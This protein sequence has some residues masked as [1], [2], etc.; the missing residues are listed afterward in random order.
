MN[1][2]DFFRPGMANRRRKLTRDLVA[3]A[4]RAHA[5]E[6]H[7][8]VQGLPA[9]LVKVMEG[10][11]G[12]ALGDWGTGGDPQLS[13]YTRLS[14]RNKSGKLLRDLTPMSQEQQTQVSHFLYATNPLAGWLIDQRTDLL[15]PGE[16]GYSIEFDPLKLGTTPKKAKDLA[17]QAKDE[18]DKFWEHAAHDIRFRGPEYLV[19][20]MVS[21]ELC[22]MIANENEV[23]GV[24]ELDYIDSQLI[25][26]VEPLG[27]SSMVPGRVLIKK[28][29]ET[30]GK[31]FDVVRYDPEA[32]RLVG[33]CFY[34]RNARILNAMRGRSELLRPADFLD[35][36][37]QYLFAQID[38]AILQNNI[39][40]RLKLEGATDGQIK[41]RI[42]DLRVELGKPGGIFGHNEKGELVAEAP[43]LA[44]GDAGELIRM[45]GNHIRGSK[46]MPESW[47]AEGGN[48][49]RATAGDQTDVAYKSLEA[50]QTVAKRIFN[51]ML[52]YAYDNL[53]ELQEGAGYPKRSEGG[54]KLTVD[55]APVRER[56]M[57]RGAETAAKTEAALELA[58]DARFISR[59]TA[60]R[61]FLQVVEKITGS[62]IDPD[63][64]EAAIQADEDEQAKQDQQR[65]N[66]L[67]RAAAEK[68][69]SDGP[70]P[71]DDPATRAPGGGNGATGQERATA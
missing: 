55:L 64:E 20:Y 53:Q 62:N 69:L 44:A 31:P 5:T 32:E 38:R 17:A 46:S 51:P 2:R 33:Q 9:D 42:K 49:N 12:T 52:W 19:T 4:G 7:T 36:F 34:S 8:F 54:V 60:R 48:A 23:T 13:G 63:D 15:I 1:W 50:W 24:P 41:E 28:P 65:A 11:S 29:G 66:D 59:K 27:G 61:I 70:N 45:L 43:Q 3:R 30:T 58:V 35:S 56:D 68:A 6:I 10:L 26:D 16:V 57:A 18:L 47:Y 14:G 37:D 39:V 25:T 67:A 71:E 40:W 21:G 22:I